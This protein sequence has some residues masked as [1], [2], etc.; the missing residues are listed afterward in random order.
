MEQN[1][2]FTT[3]TVRCRCSIAKYE[4]H[5]WRLLL[6]HTATA[7]CDLES[8]KSAIWES[9]GELI[10][11]L[12]RRNFWNRFYPNWG[13]WMLKIFEKRWRFE[14]LMKSCN[15]IFFLA[16]IFHEIHT[17]KLN[18]Q[19]SPHCTKN[20]VSNATSTNLAAYFFFQTKKLKDWY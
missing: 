20:E 1:C 14:L 6:P 3:T 7:Q 11:H 8:Q 16:L 12:L 17:V 5:I 4:N 9:F 15:N 18:N 10:F 19:T 13:Y 2:I